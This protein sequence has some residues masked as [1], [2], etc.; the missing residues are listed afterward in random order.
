[1]ARPG[2][3]NQGGQL[4]R[5]AEDDNSKIDHD[6]ISSGLGEL[7]SLGC[8]V[9]GRWSPQ[10]IELVPK[11]AR[12]R[13]RGLHVRI[14]RG[15]ALSLQHRWWA[16]LGLALQRSVAHIVLSSAAGVD[17]VTSGLEPT[18]ALGDLSA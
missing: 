11:L 3:S 2:T 9:Y 16:I 18:P 1:M 4:L 13:K 6:V 15:I 14:H 12:E 5:S 17:L 7:L 8:E 10:C